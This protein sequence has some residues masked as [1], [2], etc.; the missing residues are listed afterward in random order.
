MK[1]LSFDVGIKNLAACILEWDDTS[2]IKQN[3][4]IHYWSIINLLTSQNN[5]EQSNNNYQCCVKTSKGLECDKKVKSFAEFNGIKYCFC[6]KHLSSKD[7]YLKNI[8]NS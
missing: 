5:M 8:L 6:T 3:L 7:D 2:N 1:I 4:K